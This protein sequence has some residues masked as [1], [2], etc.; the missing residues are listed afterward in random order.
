MHMKGGNNIYFDSGILKD[1]KFQSISICTEERTII[2]FCH[3]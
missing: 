1:K 3:Y 2:H